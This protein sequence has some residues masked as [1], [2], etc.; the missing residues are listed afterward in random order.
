MDHLLLSKDL[1]PFKTKQGCVTLWPLG[2][3]ILVVGLVQCWIVEEEHRQQ[4][5]AVVLKAVVNKSIP[6]VLIKKLK[7]S[8][9]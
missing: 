7:D 2:L 4:N 8:G 9:S 1:N 5:P 6:M 3:V